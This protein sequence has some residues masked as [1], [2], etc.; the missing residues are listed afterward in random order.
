MGNIEAGSASDRRVVSWSRVTTTIRSGEKTET[1]RDNYSGPNSSRGNPLSPNIREAFPGMTFDKRS[2]DYI[3]NVRKVIAQDIRA[4]GGREPT[5]RDFDYWIPK[6]LGENDSTLVTSGQMTAEDYWHKR[7]LGMG[8]GPADAAKYGPWAG[9]DPSAVAPSFGG[10]WPSGW[11]L[12]ETDML[13]LLWYLRTMMG[14]M[15]WNAIF[16]RAG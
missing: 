8:A 5:Q 14:P 13:A 11:M 6:F 7:L 4:A 3:D 15:W 10:S 12:S 2:P 1:T 16:G 9:G